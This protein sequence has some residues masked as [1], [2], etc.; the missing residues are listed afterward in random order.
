[1][2]LFLSPL[3]FFGLPLFLFL[4]LC[5]SLS[6]VFLSS[7]L[8]FFLLSFCFLFCLFCIFLSSLLLFHEKNNMNFFNCNL[9]ISWNIFSLFWFPVFLFLSNPF[10]LSL[11]FPDVKL[12]FLFNINVFGF[13]KSWKTPI[14]GQK[15]SCNKTFFFFYE[16]VFWKMWKV[17]VFC[18]FF[19]N[20][21]YVQKHY[22]NRYFSTF[23]KTKKTEK[24]HFEVLLSGPSRCYYLG[25]VDCNLKMVNL[26]Q[27]ITPQIC[28]R[29][30]FQ[31]KKAWNPYSNS[32][33]VTNSV[34]VKKKQTWPR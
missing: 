11:L 17:I 21:D 13:K 26:A 4:F 27:I 29:N 22:K 34:F 15:G 19:K 6:L 32:V 8:S 3:T 12:C 1:M 33:F 23:L 9:F 10:I 16:P 18:P 14:F 25:Q 24:M 20:L 5:L 2:F 30:F 28:A 31:E 7:F